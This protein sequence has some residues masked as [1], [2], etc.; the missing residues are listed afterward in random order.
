M[1]RLGSALIG[2]FVAVAACVAALQV[3][4]KASDE[5]EIK[6]LEEQLAK[7]IAARDVDKIMQLYVPDDTLHVFDVIPPRQYV[8]AGA[9]RKDFEGFLAQSV[10]PI[11]IEISD[12]SVTTDGKL[13]FV[14]YVDH[15]PSTGK[16]GKRSDNTYRIT[17][18][19][20]KIKGHWLIVHEHVS[21]PVDLAT[22]RADL[23][24]KP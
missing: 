18:C 12:L 14:H 7:A 17:D 4:A 21:V 11:V 9:Y 19:L 3:Q 10:G 16:D 1:S 22:G 20:K 8:G 5:A 24:S 13:A 2:L 6:A 15:L 23:T